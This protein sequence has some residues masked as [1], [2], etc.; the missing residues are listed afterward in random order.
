MAF[1]LAERV[2]P[3]LGPQTGAYEIQAGCT[4]A[5]ARMRSRGV[6]LDL[7]GSRCCS[8]TSLRRS[9]LKTRAEYKQACLDM[10]LAAL[11][12]KTPTTPALKRAAL[13]AILSERGACPLATHQENW[14]IVDGAQRLEPGGGLSADQGAGRLV[15]DRQASVR[16]RDRPWWRS[17]PLLPAAF[18]PIIASPPT[19][20][21]APRAL[22]RLQQM[23][24]TSE[25]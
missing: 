8:W 13:E 23:P 25:E 19:P 11:A 14:L 21:G 5:V 4:P 1:R 24:R 3:V 9:G 7:C 22:S 6:R 17:C 20:P 12:A 18:T 16:L 2:L 10:G 15:E